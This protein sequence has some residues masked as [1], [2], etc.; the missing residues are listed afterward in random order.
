[1]KRAFPAS[2][3]V[4]LSLAACSEGPTAPASVQQEA[5]PA[6]HL[7][8]R[9]IYMLDQCDPRSFNAVFGP[10]ICVNRT[11]G[12]TFDQFVA[13][14]QS[15]GTVNSWRF[16]PSNIHVT[17]TTTLDVVNQG[18]EEHTFTEVANFGGG[19]IPFLN[20]LTGDLVPAPECV[21]AS[22]PT[23]PNANVVFVP[24]GGHTHV[25]ISPGPGQKFMCCIHPW[26][27]AETN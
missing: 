4:V 1:M 20:A 2:A 3:L 25:S 26:M 8:A 23:V 27:R 10:G 5:A 21:S 6:F 15:H 7:S 18:G 12:V 11:G 13:Q 19:F 14:L 17:S 24:A 22:D 16:N 9:N